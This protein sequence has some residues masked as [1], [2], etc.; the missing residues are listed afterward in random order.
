[1]TRLERASDRASVGNG[2]KRVLGKHRGIARSLYCQRNAAVGLCTRLARCGG[3][4]TQGESTVTEIIFCRIIRYK[5]FRSA[6]GL[7][8]E[9]EWATYRL[10]AMWHIQ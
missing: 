6:S 2:L 1:M 10:L 4:Q 7:G 8:R 9:P 3:R 5:K